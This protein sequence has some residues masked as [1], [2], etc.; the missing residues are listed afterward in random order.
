MEKGFTVTTHEG[1]IH[2]LYRPHFEITRESINATCDRLED[3]CVREECGRVLLEALSPRRMLDTTDVFESG[4]R[5]AR[6]APGVM[7]AVLF[8][9]Y[10]TDELSEFFKT[11]AHNRGARV[12]YFSEKEKALE[13]LHAETDTNAKSLGNS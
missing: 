13:W 1:Y 2:V 7:V 4:T 12:K 11:V 6:I 9:D 10:K 3:I 8:Y 5:F